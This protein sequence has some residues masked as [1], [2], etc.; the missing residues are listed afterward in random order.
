MVLTGPNACKPIQRDFQ[1]DRS[2]RR[3][4]APPHNRY[5]PWC[6]G[7]GSCSPRRVSGLLDNHIHQIFSGIL[8]TD[9]TLSS[10]TMFVDTN[11]IGE[12]TRASQIGFSAVP[13]RTFRSKDGRLST[14]L[15]GMSPFTPTGMNFDKK[16]SRSNSAHFMFISRAYWSRLSSV[17][18]SEPV[19]A[20]PVW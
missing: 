2:R 5:D 18:P 14:R 20:M 12:R 3:L 6:R 16:S 7:S 19:I 13:S 9:M 11:S 1:Q 8:R 17:A 15:G 10:E 4:S